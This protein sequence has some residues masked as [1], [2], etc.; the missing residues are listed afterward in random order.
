[1]ERRA[2]ARA[3]AAT[4]AP[5]SRECRVRASVSWSAWRQARLQDTILGATAVGHPLL[6]G[7]RQR[8]A[9]HH[10]WSRGLSKRIR[11]SFPVH[12][13]RDV[14]SAVRLAKRLREAG[15]FDM[16]RGQVFNYELR[17][18]AHR[19]GANPS[20]VVANLNDF[21]AWVKQTPELGS[22]HDN[23]DFILAVAQHY[24]MATSLLDFSDDP[25]VAGFFASPDDV[26][27]LSNVGRSISCIICGDSERIQNAWAEL[28]ERQ[29]KEKG[30]RLVRIVRPDVRN[31]WRLQS[32]R[33][34]FLEV[35]V[36]PV[37]LE[38]FS[39]LLHIEFP[40]SPDR[41][42]L[43][44]REMCP[45]NKSHLETLLDQYFLIAQYPNRTRELEAIFGP[46]IRFGP[47]KLDGERAFFIDDQLPP[48]HASWDE[49]SLATWL[50]EP[51]EP[52]RS[53]PSPMEMVILADGRLTIREGYEAV[54]VQLRRACADGI[55]RAQQVKW[56]VRNEH[57][58]DLHGPAE[59]D[60]DDRL[61]LAVEM[62]TILF[63]G[64]RLKPYSDAS[65][66]RGLALYLMMCSRGGRNA[67]EALFNHILGVEFQGGSTRGRGFADARSIEAAIRSDIF[68]NVRAERVGEVRAEGPEAIL[69]ILQDP[70]RL[71][72]FP[73][74]CEL[75]AEQVLPTAAH[76]MVEGRVLPMNAARVDVFGLS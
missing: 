2:A 16:F 35:H 17:P 73:C 27:D 58:E 40:F 46:P 28:N 34:L 21:A 1:M 64:M 32:Q 66:S 30:S 57:G 55:R 53:V 29:Q 52:Y 74:F 63:D 5:D 11:Y 56:M 7:G 45:A 15:E 8:S 38:M 51:D 6:R 37:L 76:Q 61:T 31:L 9:A 70:A 59:I 20:E 33:G 23:R 69:G 47:E 18:S 43:P 48:R 12:H 24:G 60:C 49:S 50:S 42:M 65:I 62:V 22:L 36:E 10:R 72:T 67:M 25:E 44:A 19:S 39:E 71:F 13:V 68:A 4:V 26:S 3:D 75:F 41:R 14:F 54:V